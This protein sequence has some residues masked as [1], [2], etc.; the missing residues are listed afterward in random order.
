MD[1]LRGMLVMHR[2]PPMTLGS[3]RT[4]LA[5]KFAAT[6]QSFWLESGTAE[7]LSDY[8]ASLVSTTTD[9]GT[10]FGLSDLQPI[11]V[12]SA[13]PFVSGQPAELVIQPELDLDNMPDEEPGRAN[14]EDVLV[15]L[16][17]SVSVPGLL[18]ILHNAGNALTAACDTLSDT[19]ESMK[20]VARLLSNPGTKDRLMATCFCS[21]VAREFHPR[22]KAFHA[23]V[24]VDR[25][26]YVAFAALSLLELERPLRRF[27][28]KE[29][30]LPA[31][32]V[33]ARSAQKQVDI[34][35]ADE[36][37][38]SHFLV[39]SIRDR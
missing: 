4:S 11:P 6:M 26:G 3:G 2:L 35:A 30:Y 5:D 21:P 1:R 31:G 38:E 27:W 22:I 37:I 12:T 7:S 8:C 29:S 39:I 33:E 18:H 10:E 24:Y 19:V 16:E 17:A 15:S 36:A 13:L 20:A 9:L 23:K 25:W 14:H 32:H 34:D 28:C